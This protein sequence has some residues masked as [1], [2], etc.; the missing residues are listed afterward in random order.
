MEFF[1]ANQGPHP[2]MDLSDLV[3]V[4]QRSV[5]SLPHRWIFH[6]LLLVS[7]VAL[8]CMKSGA[9]HYHLDDSS[10]WVGSRLCRSLLRLRKCVENISPRMISKE[11]IQHTTDIIQRFRSASPS[12]LPIDYFHGWTENRLCTWVLAIILVQRLFVDFFID[13]W[14]FSERHLNEEPRQPIR[15]DVDRLIQDKD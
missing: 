3:L 15:F 8:N 9:I 5:R 1:K 6:H 14:V 12:L 13:Q 4:P 10:M 7:V 2:P 11:H